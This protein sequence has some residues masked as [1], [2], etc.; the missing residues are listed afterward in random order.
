M[1]LVSSYTMQVQIRLQLIC[2]NDSIH[3]A[4]AIPMHKQAFDGVVNEALIHTR[5]DEIAAMHLEDVQ[6][7]Y[8]TYPPRSMR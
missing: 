6:I 7:R 2:I 4:Q 5:D 8:S 3:S 1:F